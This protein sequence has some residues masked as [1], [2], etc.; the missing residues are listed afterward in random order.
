MLR[1]LALVAALAALVWWWGLPAGLHTGCA[2]IAY[3]ARCRGAVV[4]NRCHGDLTEALPRREFRVDRG[5]QR[6]SEP[7]V[8]VSGAHPRCKVS[9]CTEWECVDEIFVRTAHGGEFREQLRPGLTPVDPTKT[10]GVVYVSAL[11]WW[12]LR[13][14]IYAQRMMRRFMR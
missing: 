11:E 7:G 12:Q 4:G 13:A 6:V 5:A 3:P 14:K 8:D 2:T 9:D 10:L 1:L